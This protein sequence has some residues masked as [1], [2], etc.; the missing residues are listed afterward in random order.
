MLHRQAVHLRP[1][2]REE[3]RRAR[4]EEEGRRLLVVVAA[5]RDRTG[6]LHGGRQKRGKI[7]GALAFGP[8]P[9]FE[10]KSDVPLNPGLYHYGIHA[11]EI[12]YTLM[13]P[14]CAAS[15]ASHEKDVDVVT[16]QWKDGRVATVRGIRSGKS[17]YGC[18][19]FAEKGVTV[20]QPQHEYD[21][22][23]T[24]QADRPLLRDEEGSRGVERHSRDDGV[25][26]VVGRSRIA[27]NHRAGRRSR[28]NS[29]SS[30]GLANAIR[31]NGGFRRNW[32]I[33][34]SEIWKWGTA[35]RMYPA[36]SGGNVIKQQ[37]T[38][39]RCA[40]RR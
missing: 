8:A 6:R 30:S 37:L 32:F 27:A 28:C 11:V 36:K 38:C 1:R 40:K 29:P 10:G 33:R 2:R 14:G 4:G 34:L 21:L 26:G 24:G 22:P 17:A 19:A 5:L 3:D 23:R 12:L 20:P 25:H 35:K 13:G 39:L 15:V 9:Y 16:G 7:L 18:T 31:H